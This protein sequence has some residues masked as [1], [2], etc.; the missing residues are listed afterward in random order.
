MKKS[1]PILG[2]GFILLVFGHLDVG[3]TETRLPAGAESSRREISTAWLS[4]SRYSE[5]P[6]IASI[7]ESLTRSST[8]SL[9]N[10][11]AFAMSAT[12]HSVLPF[13]FVL[14]VA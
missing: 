9:K 8:G 4:R 3:G 14:N 6:L 5:P 10:T 2:E 7:A 12:V 11:A 13:S 1:G